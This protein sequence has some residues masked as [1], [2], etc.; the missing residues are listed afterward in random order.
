MDTTRSL[1]W[2][3]VALG[4]ALAGLAGCASAPHSETTRLF[5]GQRSTEHRGADDLLTGG[6]GLDGLRGMT[7]PAFAD[8]AHPTDAE[9]RRRALWNNWRGIA[10]LG[11]LGNYGALYGSTANV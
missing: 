2:K 11:P 6:L 1:G 7:A 4:A 10:D 5:T 8:P 9:V 3:G